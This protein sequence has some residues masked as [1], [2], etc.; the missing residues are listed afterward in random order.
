MLWVQTKSIYF[1]AEKDQEFSQHLFDDAGKYC[2][3]KREIP[4]SWG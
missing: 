2:N 3:L 1:P 4:D